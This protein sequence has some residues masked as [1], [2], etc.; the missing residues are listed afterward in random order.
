MTTHQHFPN[1]CCPYILVYVV[2]S[3]TTS[4]LLFTAISLAHSAISSINAQHTQLRNLCENYFTQVFFDESLLDEKKANYGRVKVYM[5]E[6][7]PWSELHVANHST[8]MEY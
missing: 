8:L 7:P 6:H 4:H 1:Y 2:A 5:N 3:N